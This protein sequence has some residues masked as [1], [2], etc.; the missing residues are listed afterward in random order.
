MASLSEVVVGK[1]GVSLGVS[2]VPYMGSCLVG[3]QHI[4]SLFVVTWLLISCAV[5]LAL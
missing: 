3:V 5:R 2:V 1:G 4:Y